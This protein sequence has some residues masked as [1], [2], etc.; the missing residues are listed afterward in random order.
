MWALYKECKGAPTGEWLYVWYKA[1]KEFGAYAN[2]LLGRPGAPAGPAAAGGAPSL[3]Y[4]EFTVLAGLEAA[5]R[6][7]VH[8]EAIDPDARTV[9]LAALEERGLVREGALTDAGAS[10]LEPYRVERAVLLAAGFGSRLLPVTVNTPKPL[11]RVHGVR[12]IDRLIDA[13]Q[14]AGIKEVYVVRGY[15]SEEFDQLLRKYPDLVFIENPLYAKTNNISSAAAACRCFS[16]AYVFE[17]DLFLQNPSLVSA[18]QYR[19]NYLAIPVERTD[20]WC[21]DADEEGR[22]VHIGKGKEAPCWQMVG[23]SYWTAEDGKRLARDIPAVFAQEDGKQIF[24]DD[25]ALDR[26]PDAYDVR[27]RPCSE[28]DIVEIDDFE[29]LQRIDPAYVVMRKGT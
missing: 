18:Y 13:V 7:A 9:A 12:I 16:N 17:S 10:A 11:A 29:D 26:L 23:V 15:L 22:I 3:S 5:A 27:V 28:D 21:F 4:D 20:D 1:A 14:A 2:G 19:S 24:W 6:G 8:P 25:V